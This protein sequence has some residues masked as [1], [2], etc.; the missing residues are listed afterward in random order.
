[1]FFNPILQPKATKFK[2][3]AK[4]KEVDEFVDPECIVCAGISLIA[5]SDLYLDVDLYPQ[6]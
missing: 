3:R 4:V 1:M 2:K 6:A 5:L